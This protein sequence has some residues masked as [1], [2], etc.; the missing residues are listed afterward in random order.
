MESEEAL[1]QRHK[2]KSVKRKAFQDKLV[3]AADKEKHLLMVYT[4]TGKGKST[5]AFGTMLRALG[6]GYKVGVVQ[7]I[8]GAWASGEQKA[9]ARF[10]NLV[11]YE[12]AGEGFTWDT[13]DRTRD[14]AKARE[15]WEIALKL[16]GDSSYHLVVLDELNIVLRYNYLAVDGVVN[17]LKKRK[18]HVIVTGRNA[19]PALV[20]EADLVTEMTLVKHPFREQGIKAQKGIE[21]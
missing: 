17:A 12:V 14:I 19:P 21:F 11:T 8:K 13:Q 5:A 10:E 3:A 6:H 20:E 2:E 15:A 1:N 4:G 18:M 9:L 16:I 7:F